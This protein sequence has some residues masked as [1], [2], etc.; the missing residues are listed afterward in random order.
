VS[1]TNDGA[2]VATYYAS[3]RDSV[4]GN[5]CVDDPGW[6]D[7]GDDLTLT[8]CPHPGW[9]PVGCRRTTPTAMRPSPSGSGAISRAVPSARST[10]RSPSE[11]ETG[12]FPS[13]VSRISRAGSYPSTRLLPG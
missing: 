5:H 8:D 11:A 4:P 9:R 6:N 3:V 2:R 7:T 13:F 12:A 10:S 1:F